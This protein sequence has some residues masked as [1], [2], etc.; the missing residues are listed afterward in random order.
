V[1]TE[2][3]RA[4]LL[5]LNLVGGSLG[6]AEPQQANAIERSDQVL[7]MGQRAPAPSRGIGFA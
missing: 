1:V 6:T 7:A 2:R 5:D 3:L 4:C